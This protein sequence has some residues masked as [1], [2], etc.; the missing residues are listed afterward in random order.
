VTRLSTRLRRS[1]STGEQA[2]TGAFAF[3]R[4]LRPAVVAP[5]EWP[6]SRRLYERLT[7]ELV[8]TVKQKMLE[9]P[10]LRSMVEYEAS[11]APEWWFVVLNLGA[12]FEIDEIAE[13][14]GLPRAQPPER[15][16]TMA[17]GPL[18]AAGGL[19]EADLI[20][21]ALTSAGATIEQ[22][23]AALD[24]GCSSGRV[25]RALTA[26]YPQIQWLGCDPNRPAIRWASENLP[27]AEFFDSDNEPPLR[28][29]TGALDLAYAISVWSHLEPSLGLRWFDEMHRVIRPGGH[30]L[31]TT[32]GLTSIAH[33]AE[34][35]RRSAS[36]L[37]EIRRAMYS[38]GWWYAP[39]FG[40]EGDWGVVNPRWGTAFVSPEWL[41][42]QLCPRWRLLEFAPG[43]VDYNQDVYVLERV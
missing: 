42:S 25:I 27:T 8:A 11:G 20:V 12:W 24:F 9:A 15:V 23:R 19:Y 5:D 13:R 43:R 3:A 30:L 6:V 29:G 32:H 16:H 35:E 21:S 31:S 18:A 28:V 22:V 36:Q 41:L 14:T 33:A 26:A 7:P 40:E 2:D 10:E 4:D 1:R 34:R 37:E 39:E 38:R 17:R